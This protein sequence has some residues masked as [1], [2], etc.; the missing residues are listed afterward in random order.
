MTGKL[1]RRAVRTGL[2]V[3]GVT[4]AVAAI[5]V[6]WSM[7][8]RRDNS[9]AP[10]VA[11]KPTTTQY[12]QQHNMGEIWSG[13]KVVHNFI[14]KNP[15]NRRIR[16][17]SEADVQR[18]CGCTSIETSTKILHPGQEAGILVTIN[19]SQPDGMIAQKATIQWWPE[20]GEP[21]VVNC[22]LQATIKLA[23]T[24]DP[25]FMEFSEAELESGR[26]KEFRIVSRVPIDWSTLH[27]IK[28]SEYIKLS[29]VVVSPDDSRLAF[30]SLRFSI[31]Q[32]TGGITATI[33]AIARIHPDSP[34]LQPFDSTGFAT[35]VAKHEVQI[36]WKP[37]RLLV[38]TDAS[39]GKAVGRLWFSG[40]TLLGL[41]NPI[42]SVRV[43]GHDL[44]H[45]VTPT[46]DNAF[47][48]QLEL[49]DDDLGPNE[50]AGEIEVELKDALRFKVPFLRQRS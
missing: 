10:A 7:A 33:R 34:S 2:V 26:S 45:V 49:S 17:K 8:R 39:K 30:A 41:K 16:I 22:R 31:P 3:L 35:A 19:T 42:S 23:I 4:V 47:L 14:F 36:A 27:L 13:Q 46:A 37:S 15:V 24:I 44:P 1:E 11:A 12:D 29:D 25:P 18:T 38:S 43:K 50:P 20:S 6:G 5:F 28:S 32:D 9:S 40:K 48:L 21:I